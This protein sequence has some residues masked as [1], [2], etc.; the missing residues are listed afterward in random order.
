MKFAAY[1]FP[2]LSCYMSKDDNRAPFSEIFS[3]RI[4]LYNI[5]AGKEHN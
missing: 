2:F 5:D 3:S 4:F 1:D